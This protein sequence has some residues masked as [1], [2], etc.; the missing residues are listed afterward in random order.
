MVDAAVGGKTGINTAEGKNLVGAFH[1]PAGSARGFAR[2]APRSQAREKTPAAAM[3]AAAPTA[4]KLIPRVKASRAAV[5]TASAVSPGSRAAA[6]VAPPSVS[7][8]ASA[9]GIPAGRASVI[10]RL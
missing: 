8:T 3:T 6:A 10:S 9:C 2:P 5:S 4:A 1:P 7:R